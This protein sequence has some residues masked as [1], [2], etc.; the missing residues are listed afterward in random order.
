MKKFNLSD[1]IKTLVHGVSKLGL[2][3]AIG[4]VLALSV[5]AINDVPLSN[6]LSTGSETKNSVQDANQVESNSNEIDDDSDV[7]SIDDWVNDVVASA[8]RLVQDALGNGSLLVNGLSVNQDVMTGA[9]T[10]TETPTS[11]NTVIGVQD[12]TTGATGKTVTITT[13]A[14]DGTPIT[15]VMA[16]RGDDDDDDDDYFKEDDDDEEDDNYDDHDEDDDEDED[17]EDDEEDRD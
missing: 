9:S 12:T 11:G 8:T 7:D 3:L 16:V 5:N 10:V 2:A 15:T 17:D 13:Y 6:Y 4:G 14:P 1:L